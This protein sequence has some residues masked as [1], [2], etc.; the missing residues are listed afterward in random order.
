MPAGV[1]GGVTDM[2]DAP[3]PSGVAAL[4]Q[5]KLLTFLLAV[6]LVLGIGVE[7]VSLWKG[8]SDAESAKATADY[9][10]R[11]KQAEAL[12]A[13]QKALTEQQTAINAETLKRAEADLARQKDLVEQQAA[14]NA[15]V[16]K[17]AEA[18][19]MVGEAA[20]AQARAK[21]DEA[22]NDAIARIYKKDGS[23]SEAIVRDLIAL[24]APK[25]LKTP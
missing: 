3:Q 7:V 1:I 24:T 13:Q 4:L 14:A 23:D 12:L 9:A 10:D 11:L 21:G 18:D 16:L 5:N 20:S 25:A 17:R 19:K 22:I 2:A 15:E 8:F 6:T